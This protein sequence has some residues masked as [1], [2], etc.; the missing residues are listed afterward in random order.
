MSPVRQPVRT[1]FFGSGSFALPILDALIGAPE[2][3]LVGIVS[4][5]D[6]PAGRRGAVTATPV[7]ARA[8][9]LGLT[10]HQP[11]ALRSDVV[12]AALGELRPELGVLA[13]YGRILPQVLLDVFRLGILNVHPS[14]LP[15]HRGA[16]PIPATILAGDPAAGVSVIRMDA[17]MDTGPI[18][19]AADWPLDPGATTPALE[20]QSAREGGD[21]VRSV[22]AGWIAGSLTAR[23]QDEA[24][25]T[26]TRPLRREDG[27]L[28][29]RRPA[30]ELERQV[31]A[32]EPWPG[33]FVE[34]DAGRLTIV[35]TAISAL[36]SQDQPGRLVKQDRFPALT[37][38]DRRLILEEVLPSGGRRMSGP[39]FLRGRGRDLVGSTVR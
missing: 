39:E 26:I 28:D 14:L 29:L 27:H 30:V 25:A 12:R 37:T 23:P 18:V 6:R 10:L 20:A 15:R 7:A 22:L 21:L 4:A 5:P 34:T 24:A 31:R 33:S 35:R 9:E 13:D 36:T 1:V 16:S 17:G 2:V 11:A 38:A 3:A 8:R 19:A 32:Y